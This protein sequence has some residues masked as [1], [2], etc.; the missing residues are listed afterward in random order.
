M[1][2]KRGDIVY[3]FGLTEK[4]NKINNK[5]YE[6]HDAYNRGMTA[7]L[8]GFPFG[9]SYEKLLLLSRSK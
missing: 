6:I 7:W 5:I 4:Y 8:I 9:V 1:N 3:L 2:F